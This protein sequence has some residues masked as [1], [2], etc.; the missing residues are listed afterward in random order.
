MEPIHFKIIF[1][2][3]YKPVVDFQK[4]KL[5]YIDSRPLIS[6]EK[7]INVVFQDTSLSFLV[8][9]KINYNSTTLKKNIKPI[10][11]PYDKLHNKM[12]QVKFLKKL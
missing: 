11:M 9:L 12:M 4:Y 8:G 2:V 3:K 10:L 5:E 1:F 7:Y 6:S